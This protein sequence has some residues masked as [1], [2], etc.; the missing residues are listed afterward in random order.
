MGSRLFPDS[1][2]SAASSPAM[3]CNSVLLPLPLS[4]VSATLSLAPTLKFTPRSTATVSFA[5]R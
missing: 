4:P 2:P 3:R 1:P 5:E